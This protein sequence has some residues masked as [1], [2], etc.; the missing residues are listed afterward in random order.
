MIPRLHYASGMLQTTAY[1]LLGHM[2]P[3]LGILDFN[4]EIKGVFL[5]GLTIQK[6]KMCLGILRPN[7]GD[8]VVAFCLI[9]A[10]DYRLLTFGPYGTKLG[11]S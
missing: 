5:A 8:P 9:N 1:L 3:N 2:A 4:E 7:W 6:K 10:A 11:Q